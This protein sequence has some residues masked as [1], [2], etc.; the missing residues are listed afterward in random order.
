MPP[1]PDAA[2][3]S[4]A[5]PAA[6]AGSDTVAEVDAVPVEPGPPVDEVEA[7]REAARAATSPLAGP[8]GQPLHP[9][10]VGIP[11]GAW[12][13][14]F[15]F[16]LAA[17]AANEELVYARGAF[18]LVG[19]GIVGALA[20]GTAGVLDLLAIPRGTVA[21]RTG[22]RHLV[23][24][25]VVLVLFVVSFLLRRDDSLQAAGVPVMVL[26]VVA[27]ALLAVA[28]WLGVRLAHRYG[29][30]VAD[31]DTQRSGFVL[32]AE[33]GGPEDGAAPTD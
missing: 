27:L 26:S 1:E 23:L 19:A 29:V 14:S 7:R 31:E 8:V 6:A 16:D 13:L 28:G 17:H 32:L 25:D 18:W 30:R 9:L 3:D 20:A 10:L 22:V 11:I 4:D 15:A 21:W 12:V 24:T 2:A 33:R 5:A